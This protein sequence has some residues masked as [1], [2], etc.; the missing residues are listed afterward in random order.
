MTDDWRRAA[1]DFLV[2]EAHLLDN[3]ELQAWLETLSEGIDYRAPIRITR[4]DAVG[5][6]YSD[7]SFHFKETYGSLKARVDRFQTEYAWSEDPPS[8]TRRFVSNVYVE[9]HD[10]GEGTDVR[11]YLLLYRSQGDTT[12]ADLLSG[13]RHDELRQEDGELKL[14]QREI[15]LDHTILGT[16]NLSVFL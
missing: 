14:A 6:Y 16:K 15:R 7:D 2:R 10:D 4:E 3:R 1:T 9:P 12:D 13:E 5:P 11:S 8:R